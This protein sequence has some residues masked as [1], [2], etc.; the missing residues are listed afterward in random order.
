M[1]QTGSLTWSLVQLHTIGSVT[2]SRL[3][4]NWRLV[5][6]WPVNTVLH[7]VYYNFHC[8]E[9]SIEKCHRGRSLVLRHMY[10]KTVFTVL[11]ALMNLMLA[12]LIC[13]TCSQSAVCCSLWYLIHAIDETALPAHCAAL[14]NTQT[15]ERE[16]LC[17]MIHSS[18]SGEESFWAATFIIA[19]TLG[20]SD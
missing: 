5:T 7:S 2:V 14:I 4:T 20:E 1:F 11:F 12:L 3:A 10:R 19:D 18:Q 17:V 16:Q 8:L 6:S 9:Q 13:L 15:W